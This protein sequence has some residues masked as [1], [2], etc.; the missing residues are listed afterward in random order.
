MIKGFANG[1]YF[2]RVLNVPF[3]TVLMRNRGIKNAANNNVNIVIV[4]FVASSLF[5]IATA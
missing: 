4:A 2:K 1:L 3:L 5:I